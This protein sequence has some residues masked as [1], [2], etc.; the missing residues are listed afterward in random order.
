MLR[1]AS[2]ES[3]TGLRERKVLKLCLK[4]ADRLL[5]QSRVFRRPARFWRPTN[6][7]SRPFPRHDRHDHRLRRLGPRRALEVLEPRIRVSGTSGGLPGV[8]FRF[9]RVWL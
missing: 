8:L 3:L 7:A 5:R 2:V 6:E 4:A 9:G 1:S